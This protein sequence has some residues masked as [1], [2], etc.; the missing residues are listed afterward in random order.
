MLRVEHLDYKSEKSLS[1]EAMDSSEE[2]PELNRNL[3]PDIE[4]FSTGFLKVSDIHSIY[5]EQSG[6]PNGH[7]RLLDKML[8]C[9]L[10]SLYNSP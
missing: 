6:N 10:M 7:V 3:Y 8:M 5:W 2:I 1:V 9:N 4:P